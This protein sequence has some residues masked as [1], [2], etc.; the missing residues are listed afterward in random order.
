MLHVAAQYTGVYVD[1][2][3]RRLQQPVAVT[4]PGATVGVGQGGTPVDV[5]YPVSA[6]TMTLCCIAC[7]VDMTLYCMFCNM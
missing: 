7:N 1:Q 3:R 2:G 4:A 6:D 5:T